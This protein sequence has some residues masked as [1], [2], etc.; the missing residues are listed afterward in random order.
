MKLVFATLLVLSSVQALA[1]A[2]AVD[3]SQAA[4]GKVTVKVVGQTIE[5]SA[6]AKLAFS[7]FARLPENVKAI[8]AI[9]KKAA[10]DSDAQASQC[11]LGKVNVLETASWNA[12]RPYGSYND[13]TDKTTYSMGGESTQLVTQT[14]SCGGIGTGLY[15]G[16][17][18]TIAMTMKVD[19]SLD[20]GDI[21]DNSSTT[22]QTLVITAPS[23]VSLPK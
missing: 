8:G 6:A 2:P 17:V 5:Q 7:C 21:E 3:C 16:V 14:Y 20:L 10:D 1:A 23:L 12:G 13:K 22:V 4:K 15:E 9:V 19:N 11:S 18:A